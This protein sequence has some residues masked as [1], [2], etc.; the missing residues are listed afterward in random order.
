[1]NIEKES[2]LRQ[3]R[4]QAEHSLLGALLIMAVP[5]AVREVS[6][7]VVPKD[8]HDC[9]RQPPHN[10]HYRIFCA[11]QSVAAEGHSADQITVGQKLYETIN[12]SHGGDRTNCDVSDIAEMS[13]MIAS[14]PCSLD[15]MD[16]AQVVQRYSL[17]RAID[18]Y[19]ET[20][21]QDKLAAVLARRL[22][23]T[24]TATLPIIRRV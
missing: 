16:Y 1:M 12:Q 13:G 5:S 19:T 22:P 7:I 14:V 9:T 15:Y 20:G 2:L 3:L 21:E 23:R 10:Q 17:Q 4:E 24:R 18:Y 6:N 11:M 8:F